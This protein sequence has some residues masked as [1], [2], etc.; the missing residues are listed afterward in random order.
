[1]ELK[2][3]QEIQSSNWRNLKHSG[4]K[5]CSP[6]S[7][8]MQRLLLFLALLA[9]CTWGRQFEKDPAYNKEEPPPFLEGMNKTFVQATFNLRNILE[10]S[11]SL[12]RISLEVGISNISM[13]PAPKLFAQ[14]CLSL[15]SG[16]TQ[17]LK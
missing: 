9:S 2:I 16:T 17:G 10:M 6:L 13:V 15:F 11:E 7:S 8:S 1:M 4:D 14:R 3:C 5:C 12:Q